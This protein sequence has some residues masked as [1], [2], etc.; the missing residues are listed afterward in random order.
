MTAFIDRLVLKTSSD[1]PAT[2]RT[3]LGIF[4]PNAL[5]RGEIVVGTRASDPSLYTLNNDNTVVRLQGYRP[6]P[7]YYY[8]QV[9]LL[10]NAEPGNFDKSINNVSPA[11]DISSFLNAFSRHGDFSF[12]FNGT[13]RIQA[14]FSANTYPTNIFTVDCWVYFDNLTGNKGIFTFTR[15][16]GIL[17]V[18]C[19]YNSSTNRVTAELNTNA[20][21]FFTSSAAAPPVGQW[22][23][24]AL[25]R[26]GDSF[27]VFLNGVGGSSTAISGSFPGNEAYWGIGINRLYGA[28]TPT[29]Y[30][31][32]YID[33]FRVTNNVARYLSNFTPS[34][35][36]A[37][38]IPATE[39]AIALNGLSN[40]SITN[41]TTG[42]ALMFNGT[43]WVNGAP[44]S[45][46]LNDLPDVNFTGLAAGDYMIYDG[47]NWVNK[48]VNSKWFISGDGGNFDS[49]TVAVTGNYTLN[50][51]LIT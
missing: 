46:F 34:E 26:N 39:D 19:T 2:L 12:R 11:N 14:A 42:Q 38:T 30:L 16:D 25:V 3:D 51:G 21:Q 20:G 28:Q 23:H 48:Q 10:L 24:L 47:S 50:G 43:T 15:T 44:I 29:V 45:A 32:G 5:Q 22:V 4:G 8:N 17:T 9:D 7:D 13:T 40:V 49:G 36:P 33:D 41:P 1:T 31:T 6:A 18:A 37:S 27:Q 35:Y